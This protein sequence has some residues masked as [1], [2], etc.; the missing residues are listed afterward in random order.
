MI[1]R[2]SNY[3]ERVHQFVHKVEHLAGVQA[4]SGGQEV[5]GAVSAHRLGGFAGISSKVV[6]DDIEPGKALNRRPGRVV[7]AFQV[8]YILV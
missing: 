1:E 6:T 4:V 7:V 8:E 5:A 3:L 2:R